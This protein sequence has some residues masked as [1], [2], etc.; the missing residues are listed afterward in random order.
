M[1]TA[2][3]SLFL[4]MLH[5]IMAALYVIVPQVRAI[6][7]M[8]V[9]LFAG[10]IISLKIFPRIFPPDFIWSQVENYIIISCAYYSFGSALPAFLVSAL[11][12]ICCVLLV[13]LWQHI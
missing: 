1:Q 9:F 5:V 8:S 2:L 13:I 6:A 10:I 11:L 7:A 4:I 12:I 3:L